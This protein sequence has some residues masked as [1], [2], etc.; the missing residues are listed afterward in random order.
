MT[1]LGEV[2]PELG[3]EGAEGEGSQEAGR[4]SLGQGGYQACVCQARLR[5]GWTP[6][7]PIISKVGEKRHWQ[8]NLRNPNSS[9]RKKTGF[10]TGC[11]D[12]C[13]KHFVYV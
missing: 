3:R 1:T 9:T 11:L 12:N 7:T 6:R 2:D 5:C 4:G 13:Q 10:L 8:N